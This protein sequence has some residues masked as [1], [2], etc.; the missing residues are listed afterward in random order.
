MRS[1]NVQVDQSIIPPKQHAIAKPN[2]NAPAARIDDT[3]EEAQSRVEWVVVPY[4]QDA[5]EGDSEWTFKARDQAGLD[6]AQKLLADAIEQAEKCSSKGF[7]TLPDRAAFPRI[8]GAK[9]ATVARL[10]A[11]TGAEITV[12]RD[13]NTIVIVGKLTPPF[14]NDSRF[15]QLQAPSHRSSRPRKPS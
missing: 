6:R 4:Y 8:V 7:L 9:G 12:G 15:H 2:A 3:E 14:A 10:R 1:F 13:D 5:E 11:D